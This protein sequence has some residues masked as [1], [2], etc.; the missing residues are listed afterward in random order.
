MSRR[1]RAIWVSCSLFLL[2]ESARAQS[3]V[4]RA[5][6]ATSSQRALAEV[7]FRQGRELMDQKRTAEAC[8]KFAESLRLDVALGTSLNLAVCFETQGRLASAWS[9][10]HRAA[11]LARRAG[12]TAR[13]DY[14]E[15]AL[16]RLESL[17]ATLRVTLSPEAR[18]IRGLTLELDGKELGAATLDTPIPLDAGSHVLVARAEGHQPWSAQVHATAETRAMAL[19]VPALL[20]VPAPVAHSAPAPP[21][22]RA[23]S[24]PKKT[25]DRPQTQ[26]WLGIA[27]AGTGVAGVAVGSVFGLRALSKKGQRD[28]ACP[29]RGCSPAGIEAHRDARDAASVANVAFAAGGAFLVAGGWLYF[30]AP[31]APV[32]FTAS[33]GSV[34]LSVHRSW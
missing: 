12:D 11:S 16:K 13:S 34:Y 7:L 30:T 3:D 1:R 32:A 31:E 33:P 6:E 26:R 23:P 24:T 9:E 4:E 29:A 15:Q 19:T 20:P 14:A 22:H 28:D 21:A 17:L 10:Y 25:P 8:A 5:A 2:V 27:A 18:G